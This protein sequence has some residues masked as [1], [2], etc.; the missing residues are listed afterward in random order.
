MAT[1]NVFLEATA[2]DDVGDMTS[3]FVQ[4]GNETTFEFKGSDMT[5]EFL[6]SE[7]AVSSL[8]SDIERFSTINKAVDTGNIL[9]SYIAKG[10]IGNIADFPFVIGNM[11]LDVSEYAT[12]FPKGRAALPSQNF[13]NIDTGLLFDPERASDN[14]ALKKK[15]R[16]VGIGLEFGSGFLTPQATMAK[17]AAGEDLARIRNVPFGT[18]ITRLQRFLPTKG[19]QG[20]TPTRTQVSPLPV[21]SQRAPGTLTQQITSPRANFVTGVMGATSALGSGGASY[22]SEGDPLAEL[23]GGI[24]TPFAALA[25]AKATTYALQK[26]KQLRAISPFGEDKTSS[27][28]ALELIQKHASDKTLAVANLRQAIEQGRTGSL[29]TLTGDEGIASITNYL[30]NKN[31]EFGRKLG[32]INESSMRQLRENI[33]VLSPEASQLYFKNYIQGRE[34]A[35][36][37]VANGLLDDAYAKYRTDLQRVENG[38]IPA[39]EASENLAQA[40][41]LADEAGSNIIRDAWEGLKNPFVSRKNVLDFTKRV[42]D[43]DVPILSTDQQKKAVGKSFQG[44]IDTLR[45]TAEKGRVSIDELIKFRSNI[46]SELRSLQ[47][48]SKTNPTI[49]AFGQQLQSDALDLILKAP[50]KGD[51]YRQA[52]KITRDVKAIFEKLPFNITDEKTVGSNIF[53]TGEKGFSNADRLAKI[54]GYNEGVFGAANDYIRQAFASNIDVETGV[55]NMRSAKEFMKKHQETLSRP[56]YRALRDEFEQAIQSGRA[57][58]DLVAKVP[59]FRANRAKQA[60]NT[61]SLFDD[62]LEGVRTVLR[63]KSP[64][65]DAK[66]L[67]RQANKDPSGLA[68]EGLQRNFIDTILKNS[69]AFNAEGRLVTLPSA[70]TKYTKLRNAAKIVFENKPES[71]KVL[72]DTVASIEKQMLL[73]KARPTTELAATNAL[74]DTLFRLAGVRVGRMVGNDIQTPA[75]FAQMFR[76]LGIDAPLTKTTAQL[77]NLI[78]EPQAYSRLLKEA[79]DTPDQVEIMTRAMQVDDILLQGVIQSSAREEEIQNLAQDFGM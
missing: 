54:A 18:D 32:D 53:K 67:V 59:K 75:L 10:T 44:Y 7:P 41:K 4:G 60:F 51:S 29:A 20:I 55:L 63:S 65:K 47:G 70:S 64:T 28:A 21:G 56:E 1:N 30:K 71:L 33:D 22:F 12:G 78:L 27:E 19:S 6:D 34:E 23:F 79:L 68:L 8:S 24:A 37:S 77:E 25:G 57:S 76:R 73:N 9:A 38:V 35:I 26:G 16:P 5:N 17:L 15:L 3:E 66:L 74:A 61:Y 46:L 14:E 69:F 2:S 50:G 43:R 49:I 52:S 11:L 42:T 72:D 48:Q 62:P 40:I 31:S 39:S 13:L 36:N 58:E 45:N